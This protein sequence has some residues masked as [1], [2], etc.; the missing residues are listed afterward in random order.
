MVFIGASN[1]LGGFESGVAGQFIG[2]SGAVVLGG[3]ATLLVAGTWWWLFPALRRV[4]RFPGLSGTAR[5]PAPAPAPDP[6]PELPG[7]DGSEIGPSR[8]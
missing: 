5:D 4:D 6:E 1:E 7:R 3:A 8:R 2:V